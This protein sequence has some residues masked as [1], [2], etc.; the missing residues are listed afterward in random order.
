MISVAILE[1]DVLMQARLVEIL[2]S[3]HFVQDVCAVNSNAEFAVVCEKVTFDVLLADLNVA[4]G[5]GIDSVRLLTRI[6]PKAISIIISSNSKPDIIIK[7]I[8][9]G[10]LGYI[11]KDDS[12]LEIIQSIRC[13]LQGE[14]PISSGIAFTI[15]KSLQEPE[16]ILSVEIEKEKKDLLSARE[17]EIIQLISRGMSNSEVGKILGLSKN[18]IPVHVRNIYRKLGTTRRTEAVFEARQLGII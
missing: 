14:A 8:K 9:A 10:A 15:L 4:D 13:A 3:W 12:K 5:N 11:Y 17:T 6:N 16:T 1:D 2:K 18:T 7:A